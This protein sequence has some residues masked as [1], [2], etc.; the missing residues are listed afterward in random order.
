MSGLSLSGQFVGVTFNENTRVTETRGNGI[1]VEGNLFGIGL[2]DSAPK[3][4]DSSVGVGRRS[5][6]SGERFVDTDSQPTFLIHASILPG[7][8]RLSR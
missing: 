7:G 5:L 4:S 1:M 2:V 8:M 6:K 3:H